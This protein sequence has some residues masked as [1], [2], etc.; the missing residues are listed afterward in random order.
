MVPN[1]VEE[2]HINPIT[3]NKKLN[4]DPVT[5]EL[6]PVLEENDSVGNGSF[7]CTKQHVQTC[8]LG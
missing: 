8:V 2:I 1:L 6:G 3:A 7:L 5:E 4:W